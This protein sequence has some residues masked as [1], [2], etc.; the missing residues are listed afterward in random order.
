MSK[1]ALEFLEYYEIVK[2]FIEQVGM[3][4]FAFSPLIAI[5]SLVIEFLSSF[6][7][8]TINT[9]DQN[10]TIARASNEGVGIGS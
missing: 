9:D 1:F 6:C 2:T 4:S 7:L 10:P 5:P 3:L 8:R